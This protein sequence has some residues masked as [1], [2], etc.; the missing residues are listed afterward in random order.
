MSTE[1]LV[2]LPIDLELVPT[3]QLIEELFCRYDSALL[4]LFSKTPQKGH[5]P[6]RI[7]QS[8][9]EKVGVI[10]A[11]RAAARLADKDLS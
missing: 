4:V 2:P 9:D 10:L 8:P 11:L 3:D 5:M 6:T 7:I 1:D